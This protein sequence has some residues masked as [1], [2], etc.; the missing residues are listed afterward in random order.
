MSIIKIYLNV[1]TSCGCNSTQ[2]TM[3]TTFDIDDRPASR[4]GP[5]TMG[6]TGGSELQDQSRHCGKKKNKKHYRP[7]PRQQSN[8]VSRLYNT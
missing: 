2:C 7:L 8:A 3:I 4:L 5:F 1:L 6:E